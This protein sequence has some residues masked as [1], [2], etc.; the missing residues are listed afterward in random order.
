[1][2]FLC[3][4]IEM[5][6]LCVLDMHQAS[7]ADANVSTKHVQQNALAPSMLKCLIAGELYSPILM[8]QCIYFAVT[9]TCSVLGDSSWEILGIANCK[10]S[11]RLSIL[12]SHALCLSR[13]SGS[14]SCSN[15]CQGQQ[16]TVIALVCRTHKA[17]ACR[18][19]L[20]RRFKD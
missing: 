12:C 3:Q 14:C 5:L 17:R 9:H 4:A 7:A 8:F 20:L 1:M 6:S 2:S 15:K 13:A 11:G 18:D 19:M 16:L 10:S